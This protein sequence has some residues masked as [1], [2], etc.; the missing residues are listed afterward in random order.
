[1]RIIAK[2]AIIYYCDSHPIAKT[3]LLTWYHQFSKQVFKDFNELKTVYGNASIV[4]NNRVI[5]NI[6]GNEFRLIVQLN[7][8]KASAFIIWFG[9]HQAYNKIDCVKIKFDSKILDYKTK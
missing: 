1:M 6:K 8:Q 5:F 9:T 3:A 2:G 7:L 4:A